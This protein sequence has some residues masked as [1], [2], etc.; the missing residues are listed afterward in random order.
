MRHGGRGFHGPAVD[1]NG[2]S[3]NEMHVVSCRR[4]E[5]ERETLQIKKKKVTEKACQSVFTAGGGGIE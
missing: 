2:V 4:K 5:R 1:K 3:L